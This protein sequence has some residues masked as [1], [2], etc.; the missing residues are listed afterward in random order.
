MLAAWLRASSASWLGFIFG[1]LSWW[2]VTNVGYDLSVFCVRPDSVYS[3]LMS[4]IYTFWYV[5]VRIGRCMNY[6]R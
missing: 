2:L 4:G 6:M 3:V 1:A 5:H